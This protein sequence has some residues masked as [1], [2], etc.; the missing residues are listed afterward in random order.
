MVNG[1]LFTAPV[2]DSYLLDTETG[3]MN[4]LPLE[5]G[6]SIEYA[7]CSPWRD[8][9]GRFEIVGRSVLRTGNGPR[10]LLERT[11]LARISMPEGAVEDHPADAPII[12]GR[13]CW[14]PGQPSRIVYSSGDG[15]LY[16]QDLGE[17]TASQ[18]ALSPQPIDWECPPPCR[19]A[20]MIGDPVAPIIPALGG[21]IFVSLRYKHQ[22]SEN[23]IGF[24][25]APRS[26]G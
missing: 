15:R 4:P 26:G 24:G 21:R 13:P 14:L 20:M 5:A 1:S 25:E 18:G 19:G 10:G 12:A 17:D 23:L 3:Q 6:L 9:Q 2:S 11:G 8:D 7:S 16:I 22:L